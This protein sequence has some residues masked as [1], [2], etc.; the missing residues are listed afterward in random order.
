MLINRF[1]TYLDIETT[2]L[3]WHQARITV[4]GI[5]LVNGIESRFVQ[6]FGDEVTRDSVI[7]ALN[8]T[9]AIYTFNG[10]RFDIPFINTALGINLNHMFSHR[11]L[12]YDC[13]RCNLKGGFKAVEQQLGI[14]RQ[15]KGVNGWDAVILWRRYC[16]GDKA[17]LHTLLQYNK[18]DVI[19]LK[20]LR[21]KLDG[22]V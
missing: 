1:D 14:P 20:A 16:R 6:L 9:Q 3:S 10:S 5:Y 8:G 4:F 7:L 2:G 15:L 17:A 11:D 18:E 22:L 21:E 12:M 13:W 19:N